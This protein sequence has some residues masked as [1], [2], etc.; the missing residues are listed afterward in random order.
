M[1]RSGG[2]TWRDLE[3]GR[4]GLAVGADDGVFVLAQRRTGCEGVA[5]TVVDPEVDRDS[6]D[7]PRCAPV[8]PTGTNDVA[9]SVR[10]QVIWLWAGSEV[11][12]TEDRGR[13][14]RKA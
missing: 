9:V 14:W 2:R 12:I 5:V 1:T 7:E 10:D 6:S 8:D 3:D 4:G 11:A 13:T